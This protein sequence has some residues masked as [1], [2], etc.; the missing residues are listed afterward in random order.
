[1]L[2][3]MSRIL[4]CIGLLGIFQLRAEELY[5]KT[6]LGRLIEQYLEVQSDLEAMTE[7][8]YGDILVKRSSKV[9]VR[10]ST[11][12]AAISANMRCGREAM[13]FLDEA[14]KDHSLLYPR[15]ASSNRAWLS[16]EIEP[17]GST[18]LSPSTINQRRSSA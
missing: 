15:I 1:M 17:G 5:P 12:K 7:V 16:M 18:I 11:L 8:E 2:K 9:I 13:L 10:P 3:Q 4:I 6:A 14:S